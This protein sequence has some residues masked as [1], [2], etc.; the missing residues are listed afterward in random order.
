MEIF[1]DFI[2][3]LPSAFWAI[4]GVAIGGLVTLGTSIS[5]KNLEYRNAFYTKL[6]EKRMA[7]YDELS[8][9]LLPFLTGVS[10]KEHGILVPEIVIDINEFLPA[11]IGIQK[12]KHK[13]GWFESDT[14][15]NYSGFCKML[16]KIH[17]IFV[18][19]EENPVES[20]KILI[21]SSEPLLEWVYLLQANLQHDILNLYKT[22]KFEATHFVPSLPELAKLGPEFWLKG[23]EIP[24]A[25]LKNEEE[26]LPPE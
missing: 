21:A 18:H 10:Y 5:I 15:D 12:L 23:I 16:S 4:L 7:V 24:P 2:A 14:A 17:S 8:D 13:I 20:E 11:Y 25:I 6:I 19:F 1:F 26:Q 9:A 22:P 3:N